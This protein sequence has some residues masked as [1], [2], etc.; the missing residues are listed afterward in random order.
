MTTLAS[1]CRNPVRV[2]TP[3]T[4]IRAAAEMMREHHVGAL[5]AV[6]GDAAASRPIG[7][8]TD[9]DIVIAIVALDL[10]PN[11]FLIDD[12]LDRPLIV[13]R[14][15][16]DIRDGLKLMKAKGVRRL[17]LVDDTGVLS[18]IVTLDDLLGALA[19]DM[20]QMS[21][22]VEREISSEVSLRHGRIRERQAK[23]AK[24]RGH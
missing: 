5:V 23:A 3:E 4:T 15:D 9:R 22:V 20:N 7:I 18:G 10:D 11:L 19:R 2:V 24:G 1:L 21:A 6:D 17:P 8:I 13:A 16:Q 14:A 12:L